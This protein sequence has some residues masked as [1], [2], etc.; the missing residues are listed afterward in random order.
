ME[1]DDILNKINGAKEQFYSGNQKNSFF[2]KQQ[3]FDCATSIMSNLNVTEV[4][5][6]VFVV[7]DDIIIFNYPVFKTIAHP[8]LYIQISEYLFSIST[9]LIDTYGTYKLYIICTGITVSAIERYKDF[10]SVISKK[11]LENGKGLL[12]KMV[13]IQ[14][15]NPPSFVD[16]GLKVIIP[17]VDNNLWNKISIINGSDK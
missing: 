6:N 4:L 2:K 15:Y 9:N 8:D 1:Q 13:S 12:S 14:I 10:V 7:K 11:G 17:L 16:Y 3:K 5:S